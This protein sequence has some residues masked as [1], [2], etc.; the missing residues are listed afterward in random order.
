MGKSAAQADKTAGGSKQT[1]GGHSTAL[2]GTACTAHTRER[3]T[4][5]PPAPLRSVRTSALPPAPACDGDGDAQPP[6]P[7]HTA[8]QALQRS[9]VM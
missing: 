2:A 8:L 3:S 5:D 6:G 4:V 7:R 9:D 1:A